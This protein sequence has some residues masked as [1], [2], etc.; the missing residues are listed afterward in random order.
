MPG[1][2]A[3]PPPSA[4][5]TELLEAAYRYVLDQGLADVSLR[6]LATAIGS[7]PRVLLYLF[8]S[9]DGLVRALLSRARAD[10]MAFLDRLGV[11]GRTRPVGLA[12]LAEQVWSWLAAPEH[13]PLLTLW[14]EGYAR[15]LVDPT[16][17]WAGFG[18]TTVHD[19]L[20][21]LADA[22]PPEL[23]HTPGAEAQRTAVLALLRGAFLDLLA[24]GDQE[25]TTAAVRHQLATMSE[26]RGDTAATEHT[27]VP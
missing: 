7:S 3:S 24:T 17:P 1:Q 13:R 27:R 11:D 22:Q 12:G 19:W 5:K 18:R 6:P 25:R 21:V 16:G 23:R 8:G 26:A 2:D 14:A 20:A 15:S 4:R 10:E 9:K